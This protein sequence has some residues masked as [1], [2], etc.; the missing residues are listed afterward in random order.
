[1]SSKLNNWNF[2][3]EEF[4]RR[5]KSIRKKMYDQKVEALLFCSSHGWY[6]SDG[7]YLSYVAGYHSNT[8]FEMNFVFLGLTGKPVLLGNFL[9]VMRGIINGGMEDTLE[10]LPAPILEGTGNTADYIPVIQKLIKDRKLGESKIGLVG[11][12]FFPSN[13]YKALTEQ[14]PNISLIDAEVL[15]QKTRVLK[16]DEELLFLKASGAAADKAFMAM[17]DA[18]EIGI[19]L[20]ELKKIVDKS[21]IDSG[22]D[23][24]L[25]LI[26][27][28]HWAPNKKVP[29]PASAG[30][31]PILEKGQTIMPELSSN[32]RGYTTQIATPITLGE[33][34]KEL[35]SFMELNNK[36]Y[37][38]CYETF[39]PENTIAD[40]DQA[41]NK[42]AEEFSDGKWL[43]PFS[44]QTLDHEQSFLHEDIP[45]HNGVGYIIM[46]WFVWSDG[47]QG[48][49]KSNGYIGHAWGVASIYTDKGLIN[50][51]K[52]PPK[53]IIK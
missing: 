45:I 31:S 47:A 25:Q 37:K 18:A 8:D 39:R 16:S 12:R 29:P 4:E 17:A 42:V 32:F 11:M 40:V 2:S 36:V 44:C 51:S 52:L 24:A 35:L 41:G 13:V 3:K 34:S 48:F 33:P 7:T 43:A 14:F 5:Y 15:I 23:N 50:L 30:G 27:N 10:P 26:Q 1:M 38:A 49:T 6:K 21:F 19:P 53:I 22:C 20:S 9:A 46:P 28:T